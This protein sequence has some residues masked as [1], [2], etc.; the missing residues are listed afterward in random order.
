MRFPASWD[1]TLWITTGVATGALLGALAAVAVVLLRVLP[2]ST[3]GAMAAAGLVLGLLVATLGVAWGL[4]PR[5]FAIEGRALRIER[6]LSAIEVPLGSIRAAS[7][8]P[9][10]SFRR[11]I[12]VAGSGGL[13][14][15]YGRF[16]SRPLGAFRLYATRRTGLVLVDTAG[17]RFVLSPDHPER[18]LEVLRQRAPA[19]AR[20]AEAHVTPRPMPR[21]TRAALL[22]LV[23]IVPLLAAGAVA[24]V[25]AW[26]PRG[27]AVRDG[28]IVIERNL[29]PALVIPRSDVR[30][31]GRLAPG[32]GR[33]G[34]VLG[35]SI[36]GGVRYG[37]F[38]S[39]ELGEVRLYAWRAGP[40]VLLET[41]DGRVVLTPDDPDAFVATV[42]RDAAR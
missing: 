16:W 33:F 21:R 23:S 11:A 38:R 31:A 24:G 4:A 36:P 26:S 7:A 41:V 15:Y 1:R 32:G 25:W 30:S 9:D 27:A 8:V 39:P 20:L 19:A 22:A 13:F 29:A 17:E 18:F 35:V 2:A 34:R 3:P 12:R 42:Q 28:E 6:P 10:E 14:G 37:R 40:Y 5:A